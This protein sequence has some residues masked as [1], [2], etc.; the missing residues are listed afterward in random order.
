M[1]C[2]NCGTGNPDA[3]RYCSHCGEDI[4][5]MSENAALKKCPE[6]HFENTCDARYCMKCGAAL[7]ERVRPA[8]QPRSH[9]SSAPPKKARRERSA[10]KR[11]AWYESPAILAAIGIAVVF[12]FVLY[13]LRNRQ[14][15]E[16]AATA[17]PGVILDPAL[18]PAFDKVVDRFTCGCG[19]CTEPLWECNCPTAENEK[20]LI[21]KDLGKGEK[22]TLIV[23]AVYK[24][25]GHLAAGSGTENSSGANSDYVPGSLSLPK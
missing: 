13:G 14:S 20:N 24:T 12:V 16:T 8:K 2:P 4:S 7:G 19:E 1:I 21:K 15:T 22:G 17:P 25:Y 18:K 9:R 11:K 23:D 6:C 3:S 5:S 10:Y